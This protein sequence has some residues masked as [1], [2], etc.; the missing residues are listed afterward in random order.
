M[1]SIL[2]IGHEKLPKNA[3]RDSVVV[4]GNKLFYNNGTMSE[5]HKTMTCSISVVIWNQNQVH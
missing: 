2:N 3:S 1:L 5:I 4:F